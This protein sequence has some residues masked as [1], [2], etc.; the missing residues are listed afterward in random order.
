MR[1]KAAAANKLASKKYE[2]ALTTRNKADVKQKKFE[3]EG[4]TAGQRIAARLYGVS[5]RVEG[6]N[7]TYVDYEESV[8]RQIKSL[9]DEADAAEKTGD[10]YFDLA[11][12]YEKAAKAQLDAAGIDGKHKTTKTRTREPRDLTSTINRNNIAIQKK[13]EESITELQKD[14]YAKR[15]KAAADEVQDENNRLREM[16][17][18][19][20]EYVKNV[21]GKY[22]ELTEDQKKQI[23]QQQEWITSTIANNLELLALELQQIQKEQQVNSLQ[24]QRETANSIVGTELAGQNASENKPVT[25]TQISVTQNVSGLESSLARERKLVEENLELE[26]AL[27]LSTNKKLRESGDNQARSEEEILIELGKKKLEIWSEY[28]QKILNIRKQ[29][30]EDQLDLVKKGSAEELK[31]LLEQNDI[32]RQLALAENAAKPA[33]QQIS[34]STINAKFNKSGAEIAGSFELNSFE[35]QQALDEA[36]LMK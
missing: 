5:T 15:R 16:Y 18:K 11:A 4:P 17:R 6:T 24:I 25:T 7:Y 2:E 29:N 23:A 8:K 34:T 19:N 31:L 12:G 13:Y 28:D 22:K 20:E 30:V 35:E 36:I 21:K 3:E 9:R 27:I 14:E 33:S 32:N 1:A 10:A 26:Y